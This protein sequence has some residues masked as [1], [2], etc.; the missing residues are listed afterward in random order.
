MIDLKNKIKYTHFSINLS[1]A[2]EV[3]DPLIP[4]LSDTK[5]NINVQ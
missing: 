1:S 3:V 5:H 2:E 4:K